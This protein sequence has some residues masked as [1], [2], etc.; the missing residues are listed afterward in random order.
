MK[1]SQIVFLALFFLFSISLGFSATA[2]NCGDTLSVAGDYIVSSDLS[3]SSVNGVTITSDNVSLDCQSYT[4]NSLTSGT[5]Y[6]IS[7]TAS[8]GNEYIGLNISNCAF[9]GFYRGIR[10]DYVDN[11]SI[12]N[13][14]SSNNILVGI[15]L[16]CSD[17]NTLENIRVFNNSQH[18]IN[19][20]NSYYNIFTNLNSSNNSQYGIYSR[21][22]NYN[23]FT[24]IFTND[25]LLYG[26]YNYD[27]GFN[28]FN[29]GSILDYIFDIYNYG[30]IYSNVL[31]NNNLSNLNR[32]ATLINPVSYFMDTDNFVSNTHGYV[33]KSDNVSLDCQGYEVHSLTSGTNYGISVTSSSG[34]EY[35]DINISNCVIS[36]FFRGIRFDY[37]DNSSI[38]NVSLNNNNLNGLDLDNSDYNTFDNLTIYNNGEYGINLYVGSDHNTFTNLIIFNNLKYG[39][40]SQ[41]SYYNIISN[42]YFFNNTLEDMHFVSSDYNIFFS[43]FFSNSSKFP[44]ASVNNYFYQNVGSNYLGNWWDDDNACSDPT[45][46]VSFPYDGYLYTVCNSSDYSVGSSYDK[47]VI[48]SMFDLPDPFYVSPTPKNDVKI[49][50]SNITINV[51]YDGLSIINCI[52]NFPTGS[53]LMIDGGSYCYEVLDIS[54][55][56]I[57]TYSYNVSYLD[58]GIKYLT[59]RS[60]M[61]YPG[62]DGKS[63]FPTLGFGSLISLVFI[64]FLFI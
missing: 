48:L 31:D 61:Y 2:V 22:S 45:N 26:F 40:N 16:D 29:G 51:S 27:S 52:L 20:Y 13:V 34:N 64:L 32:S 24:N 15:D 55:S 58:G 23:I 14:T 63:E 3:C 1:F 28:E 11:S 46:N 18:G 50:N 60:V 36:G 59:N 37:V 35:V 17:Y 30:T 54:S 53:I 7:A 57:T 47:G 42:S 56:E 8:S 41:S 10:F 38:I 12:I 33:I 5:N 19:S 43:N 4:I 62:R 39:I 6:G 21:A 25:N 9:S 49:S 44:S